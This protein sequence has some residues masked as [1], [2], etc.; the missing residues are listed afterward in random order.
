[1]TPIYN[2]MTEQRATM[3]CAIWGSRSLNEVLDAQAIKDGWRYLKAAPRGEKYK[4]SKWADDGVNYTESTS[5]YTEKELS[6][7]QAAAAAAAKDAAAAAA[8][9]DIAANGERYVA[10]NEYILLCDLLG[11]C[12]GKHVKL[13]MGALQTL[14][15][16][17]VS[18]AP[19]RENAM[20]QYLMGLQIALQRFGGVGWW[21]TCEWHD[22]PDIVNAAGERH[23]AIVK[24]LPV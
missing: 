19:A 6:D 15:I 21:D 3:P 12:P 10:E 11:Q 7:M 13:G 17:M 23:N 4:A 16:S 24:V 8:A 2:V 14:M 5:D 18:T 9:A 20:F 22:Q 1:M